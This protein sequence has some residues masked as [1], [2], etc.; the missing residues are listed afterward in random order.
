MKTLDGLRAIAEICRDQWG[1]VTAAQARAKGVSSAVLSRLCASGD[2]FRMRRGVYQLTHCPGEAHEFLRADWLAAEPTKLGYERL[3]ERPH[4]LVVS[5]ETASLL[6]G[7][8]N[9]RASRNEFTSPTR[10]QTQRPDIRYRIRRLPE[11]DVTMCFGFPVTTRERTIADLIEDDQDLSLVADVLRDAAGQSMLEVPR[12]V[13]LLDPLATR[14]GCATGKELLN[15]LIRIAGLDMRSLAERLIAQPGFLD[16]VIDEAFQRLSRREL[17]Q[18]TVE[19]L[20]ALDAALGSAKL[21]QLRESSQTIK[22]AFKALA[23]YEDSTPWFVRSEM[24]AL[25][26]SLALALELSDIAKRAIHTTM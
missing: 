3:K 9:L 2:L 25:S 13:E 12:L 24:K 22:D 15:R 16:L 4:S 14:K 21:D 10:R 19:K 5:G 23:A 6:L 8:G 26:Q 18:R 11:T 20:K 7:I 17:S 1:M